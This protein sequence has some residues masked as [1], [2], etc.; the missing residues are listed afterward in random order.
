MRGP[1]VRQ[2]DAINAARERAL[3]MGVEMGGRRYHSDDRFLAELTTL[4]LGYQIGVLSGTQAIRTMANETVEL[5]VLDLQELALL[6]GAYRQ[7]VYA[8]SWAEKDALP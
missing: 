7:G 8:A 5:G 2:V 4:L 1:R 6:V 3:V